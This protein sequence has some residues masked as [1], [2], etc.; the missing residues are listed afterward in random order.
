MCPKTN[1][2][3]SPM[4]EDR[5]IA[6]HDTKATLFVVNG[7]LMYY[8]FGVQLPTTFKNETS[9]NP[10]VKPVQYTTV[11]L[12]SST[13]FDFIY[14]YIMPHLNKI[15]CKYK[16]AAYGQIFIQ[17]LYACTVLRSM[18]CRVLSTHMAGD[19]MNKRDPKNIERYLPGEDLHG[20]CTVTED[21]FELRRSVPLGVCAHVLLTDVFYN[22]YAD[23]VNSQAKN[24]ANITILTDGT[25]EIEKSQDYDKTYTLAYVVWKIPHKALAMKPC[26]N[27]EI[28][29]FCSVNAHLFQNY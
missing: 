9:H 11:Y 13:P 26:S 5:S 17:S 16:N 7:M 20:T 2:L 19:V 27:E 21:G 1:I 12:Q 22:I 24:L 23:L 3:T 18:V 28:Q 14:E 15:R 29:E 10:T 25:F 8:P 4:C 6:V